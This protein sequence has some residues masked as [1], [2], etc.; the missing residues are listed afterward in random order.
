MTNL[1]SHPITKRWPPSYPDRLQLYSAPTP[2]G[3]KISIMLE[4][5]GL[6]YEAHRVNLA[7][8]E[9]HSEPFLALNPNGKIPAILD[10]TADEGP[11]VINESISILIYLADKTGQFLAPTGQA[12]YEAIQWAIWQVSGVGPNFG[13]LGYFS[14]FGGKAIDDKRP[15]QRFV[16]ESRRLLK[17]LDD[18]L[19]GKSWI[20]GNDYTIADISLLGWVR[21]LI[22]NYEAGDLVG[23]PNFKNVDRWLKV[24]LD[25]PAVQAGLNIPN[26]S[27]GE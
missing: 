18:R 14:R 5:T 24:G 20:M 25:R 19:E 11:I 22:Y 17:V 13:N 26:F 8:G 27:T 4:E 9:S 12:R 16:D 1:L 15:L 2:N 7:E 3:V 21:G 6:P 23:Y 10:P